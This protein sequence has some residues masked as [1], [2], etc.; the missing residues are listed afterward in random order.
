M[1]KS[2]P[3][4]NTP[5][6]RQFFDVVTTVIMLVLAAALVWGG[7]ARL[8]PPQSRSQV[9]VAAPE[10][11]ILIGNAPVRGDKSASVAIVEF[12]DFECPACAA[13]AR[14][15]KPV[16]LRDYV[17]TGKVFFVFKNFPLTIHPTAKILAA[18]AW[19]AG[20]QDRFWQA[21]DRLYAQTSI[22]DLA[23]M[24]GLDLPLYNTC[25]SG[26]EHDQ[27][28]EADSR[29]AEA[30]KVMA[31]PTFF[32][33]KATPDGFVQATDVLIGAGPLQRFTETIDRLL[34]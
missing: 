12:A 21:H 8:S 31:T 5:P 23:S 6:W 11:P 22:Q 30:L 29:A 15:I 1:N 9:V 2:V 33:G 28:I 10:D 32:L 26:T 27:D 7:R 18:A 16:L 19:C 4:Q 17:D 3:K 24:I 25:L 34:R 14:N 20:K 13:F